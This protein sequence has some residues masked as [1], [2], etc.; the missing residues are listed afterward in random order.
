MLVFS[1]KKNAQ[2][3]LKVIRN[4]ILNNRKKSLPQTITVTNNILSKF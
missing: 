1:H 4:K 2:Q 3:N